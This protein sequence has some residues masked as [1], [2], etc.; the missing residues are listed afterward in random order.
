[1]SSSSP[2][3]PLGQVIG[4]RYRVQSL[5]G[6]GGMGMVYAATHELTG[7]RVA[8]KL[9]LSDSDDAPVLQERFLSEARIAATVRHANIVDVLDMGLHD[10]AP[11]LVMELLEGYSL[12][13]LLEDQQRLT[14]EQALAWLL[15]VIGALAVLHDAGIVHRDV[16]PSNIFLS[17]LP[18]HPVRPK[19]LDFGLARVVSDLRLTRSGTVIGTPLYMAPEHAAGLTTGPQADIWSIGV[20]IY[21][22]LTGGSP[23]QYTD[24]ASLAAQVLAGLVRPLSQTRPDLP[25]LISVAVGRA[26]QR[27]LTRRYPDMRSFAQA[28]HAAAVTSGIAV[29]SDPDPIGLPDYI[30]WHSGEHIVATTHEHFGSTP[31]ASTPRHGSTPAWA[32]SA[33]DETMRTRSPSKRV[34]VGVLVGLAIAAVITWLATRPQLSAPTARPEPA[35]EPSQAPGVV[36]AAVGV[37]GLPEVPAKP[38]VE[39]IPPVETRPEPTPDTAREPAHGAVRSGMKRGNAR[40]PVRASSNNPVHEATPTP[41]SRKTSQ[42][43]VEA[44]WK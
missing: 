25:E 38:T 28:L 10:G 20:V 7:R 2:Q 31:R 41:P 26:L 6:R 44:E 27:D 16:K 13:K 29:P 5:I 30:R 36:P 3:L 42:D 22:V 40:R 4:S 35:S 21:E 23:F 34:L 14:V 39:S 17:T 43:E 33:Q 18:R 9:M 24:R 32:L 8:L 1:M 19:L 37:P 12:E 11:Y 15:P